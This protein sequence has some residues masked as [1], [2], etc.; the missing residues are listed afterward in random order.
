MKVDIQSKKGLRTTL[1]IVVDKNSIQKKIEERLFELQNTVN[2]K[3]FR[4]GKVPPALIKK[5][6]GKA[7][8]GEVIDKLLKETSQ[9][10]ITDKKIKIAGQ[11]KIDLKSFGE[12]KDLSYELQIDS[13]PEIKLKDLENFKATEYNVKIDNQTIEKKLKEIADQHKQYEDKGENEKAVNGDQIIFDYEILFNKE[14][15]DKGEGKNINLILGKDL[16]IK[17]FDKQLINSK[18]NDTR[19]VEVN[20]PP[21]YPQKEFAGKKTNFKCKILKIQKPIDTKIDDKFAKNLGA[22]DIKDLKEIIEKQ[23]SSQYDQALNAITKKEILDQLEKSH[24]LQLPENL[25]ENEL[26]IMTQ[27]IKD[28]DKKK[29]ESE[30]KKLASSRIKLG[31]ILNEYGEKNNVKVTDQEIQNEINKHVKSMPGQEKLV[32]DYYQKNPSAAQSL[33]GSL[34]EEKI[35]KL[36]KSKLKLNK[37]VLQIKEAEEFISK[38][39]S[40]V[41]KKITPEN[42]KQ[43]KKSK[44]K[45]KKISKK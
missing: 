20:L 3:G 23:I 17:G 30:N 45:S 1:S 16:F 13:F 6:F 28:Q 41:K 19:D 32:L 21:N 8:Y 26:N 14:K 40:S 24:S 25:I 38:F 44:I 36:I 29:F 11:P 27:S 42:S 37:K 35:I 31:L 9:Q 7:I 2:L 22:K 4:P 5:Q 12:G 43:T 33:K 15:I 34:Y 18:Q 39:N 10:A